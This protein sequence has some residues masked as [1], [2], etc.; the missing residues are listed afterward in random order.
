MSSANGAPGKA[1]ADLAAGYLVVVNDRCHLPAATKRQAPGLASLRR[2]WHTKKYH[3]DYS[4]LMVNCRLRKIFLS[5]FQNS[6][7][8]SSRG[9]M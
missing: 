2:L 8:V 5:P 9:L 6:R 1:N 4:R 3:I 7:A